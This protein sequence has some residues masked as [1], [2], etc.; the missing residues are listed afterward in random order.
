MPW[1][2]NMKCRVYYW[3]D[4]KYLLLGLPFVKPVSKPTPE[5]VE[6]EYKLFWSGEVPDDTSPDDIFVKFNL[7]EG[8]VRLPPGIKH[9]SMSVGDIV[10]LNDQFYICM[11]LG[12]EKL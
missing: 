4:P 12:W 9:T 3:K 2:S 8:R 11:P 7:I 10:Q 6:R 1:I 5:E